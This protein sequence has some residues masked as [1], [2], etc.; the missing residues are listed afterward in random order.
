MLSREI[1]GKKK[2]DFKFMGLGLILVLQYIYQPHYAEKK[3]YPHTPESLRFYFRICV[4]LQKVVGGKKSFQE[5]SKTSL[6]GEIPKI[7]LLML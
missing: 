5:T 2:S 1:N 3:A 6:N 4:F 7:P